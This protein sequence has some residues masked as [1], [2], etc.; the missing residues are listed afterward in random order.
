MKFILYKQSA[1]NPLEK[2]V[3]IKNNL[4]QEEANKLASE[5]SKEDHKNIYWIEEHKINDIL[6]HLENI[7]RI[8]E[9]FQVEQDFVGISNMLKTFGNN[10]WSDEE[11]V[12]LLKTA[13]LATKG[14]KNHPDVKDE[15]L[16][17]KAAYEAVCERLNINAI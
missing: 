17:V 16:R 3:F 14:Y 12:N 10:R 4:T 6:K 11:E 1:D 5:M 7:Y 9:F 15:R 8:V 13:L 2:K